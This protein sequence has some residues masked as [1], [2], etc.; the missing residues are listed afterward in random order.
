MENWERKKNHWIQESQERC[1]K[2]MKLNDSP[3]YT[4]NSPVAEYELIGH[5]KTGSYGSKCAADKATEAD[6]AV[7][8]WHRCFSFIFVSSQP[9]FRRRL[10][11]AVGHR[12]I[13][14]WH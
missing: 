13:T 3:N 4:F 2:I 10:L 11:T 8:S 12:R 5:K 6:T 1:N 7:H 14:Y 9:D